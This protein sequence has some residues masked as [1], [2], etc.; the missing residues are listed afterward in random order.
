M[1]GSERSVDL[2]LASTLQPTMS[3]SRRLLAVELPSGRQPAPER[4]VQDD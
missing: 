2:H 4:Q 3:E 1:D